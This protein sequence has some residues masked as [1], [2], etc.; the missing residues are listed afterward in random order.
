MK[1]VAIGSLFFG[2]MLLYSAV[3]AGGIF[4]GDPWYGIVE[5]AY[6]AKAAATANQSSS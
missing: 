1:F 6:V 4:A 3:A 5:D 2:Y